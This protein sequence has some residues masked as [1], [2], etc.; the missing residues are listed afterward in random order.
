PTGPTPPAR[1]TRSSAGGTARPTPRAGDRSSRSRRRRDRRR[2]CRSR[3]KRRARPCARAAAHAPG[4]PRAPLRTGAS[5]S[6]GWSRSARRT[7]RARTAR[8]ADG[9]PR[10]AAPPERSRRRSAAHQRQ[11]DRELRA[12]RRRVGALE[13]PVAGAD[14][15]LAG[16]EPE[17][18]ALR[19]GRH[20]DLDVAR[21]LLGRKAGPIVADDEQDPPA[22]GIARDL[23]VDARGAA[24]P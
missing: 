16:E 9:A 7:D 2:G 3:T 5:G 19:L 21:Q 14:E 24:L 4:P 13:P 23:D 17:P 12:A 6:R 15:P 18:R 1:R 20:E 10:C 22:R 8:A 11:D